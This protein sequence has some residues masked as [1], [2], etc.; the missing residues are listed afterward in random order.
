MTTGP[1]TCTHPAEFTITTGRGGDQE[2][3]PKC[4]L[5]GTPYPLSDLMERERSADAALGKVFREVL[6]EFVGGP[7]ALKLVLRDIR[8]RI[9]KMDRKIK[10]KNK[11]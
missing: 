4:G 7:D 3:V 8:D 2:R 11:E 9:L 10:K 1:S 6:P 5:C